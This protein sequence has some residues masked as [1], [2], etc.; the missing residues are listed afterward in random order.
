MK[1]S[2][3]IFIAFAMPLCII[4]QEK[5]KQNEV[6]IAFN[7]FNNFG[8]TYKTGTDKSLWRFSTLLLNGNHSTAES[9]DSLNTSRSSIGFTI[10]AGREYRKE[11][12]DNFEFRIGLDLSFSYSY[13][14][15]DMDDKS[16][17]NENRMNQETRYEPGIN[18]VLG[19]NYM[20]NKN[21]ILGA[22][23]MPYLTY[24]SGELKE[25]IY[26]VNEGDEVKTESSGFRYGLSNTSLLLTLAY[27]F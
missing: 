7:S 3:M 15:L 4:A 14:K 6:G 27:R 17:E 22:E 8:L 25:K 18:L 19:L 9:D 13:S 20:I 2:F 16:I 26:Y 10:K 11:I 1:R 24:Y 12:L 23:L 5:N 21:L